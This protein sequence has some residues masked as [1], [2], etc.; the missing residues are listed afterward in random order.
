MGTL[1]FY[2][3]NDINKFYLGLGIDVVIILALGNLWK[4]I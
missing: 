4:T 3:T 1:L 2:L